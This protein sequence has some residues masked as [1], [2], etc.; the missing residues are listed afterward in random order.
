MA[1]PYAPFHIL[2][3]IDFNGTI[4][5]QSLARFMLLHYKITAIY[6]IIAGIKN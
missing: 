2:Y 3:I 6:I 5:H 4:I 1:F